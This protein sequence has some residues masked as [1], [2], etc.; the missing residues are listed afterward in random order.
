MDFVENL[1]PDCALT[2]KTARDLRDV[3]GPDWNAFIDR[4]RGS[5]SFDSPLFYR[6]LAWLGT[7]P[8][9]DEWMRPGGEGEKHGLNKWPLIP[10]I[11][12]GK[13]ALAGGSMSDVSDVISQDIRTTGTKDYALIGS[14]SEDGSGVALTSDTGMVVLTGSKHPEACWA[15]IRACLEEPGLTDR[16]RWQESMG[17]PALKS[18]YDEKM[19]ALSRR[20]VVKIVSDATMIFFLEGTD[21]DFIQTEA[22][23]T[24]RGSLWY[25]EP[26]DEDELSSLRAWI[27]GAGVPF[28]AALPDG[29]NE[30]IQ[31]EIDAWLHGMGTPGDCAKKIQSRVSIWLAEHS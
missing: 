1:P 8:T 30:I 31:E 13:L 27:D 4:E 19:D 17:L 5:C 12:G 18:M 2:Q 6:Y 21:P 3:I 25:L 23:K 11:T 29:V 22:D 24:A 14:P 10:Y 20:P 26:F 7:L 15:F 9:S 16:S 28:T